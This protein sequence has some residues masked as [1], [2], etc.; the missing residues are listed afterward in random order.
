M[1]KIWL[2][3]QREYLTRVR[4]KSFIIMTILG[5]ILMAAFYAL[6]ILVA[7]SEE[8][9]EH[10]VMVVDTSPV[11]LGDALKYYNIRRPNSKLRFVWKY[12]TYDQARD[13][14]YNEN[15]SSILFIPRD[16][17]AHPAGMFLA[18]KER[19]SISIKNAIE[20]ELEKIIE[21]QKLLMY[22]IDPAVFDSV[23]VKVNLF[24]K[25][26][27]ETETGVREEV[28]FA[29]QKYVVSFISGML[30]YIFI[31]MYGVQVLRGVMEEKS[32]RIVEVIVSSVKP[33]QLMMGKI[34]GIAWV[35]LT[36]FLIWVVFSGI[37]ITVL[38]LAFAPNIMDQ[39]QSGSMQTQAEF[40]GMNVGSILEL[41]QVT[42]LSVM[43]GMFI[44]Y[45]LGG[46]L[47]Y[48]SL[49]AAIGSAIDSESDSQQFMLPITMPLIFSIAIGQSVLN[50]PEGALAQIFSFI[51][52]TSPIVMMVRI[53]FGVAYWELAVSAL[54]LIG[55]FVFTT[56][57]AARI[58]RTGI[59]MYGKKVTYKELWKWLWYKG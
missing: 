46:Y 39:V 3:I 6:L 26:I 35:G 18:F 2:V 51:P 23:R 28:E 33:F 11:K 29:E 45:F 16:P 14:I 49:F 17:V 21:E 8:E 24:E 13:S 12:D 37:V 38:S 34:I 52:L 10:R 20:I 5:P 58:Y 31:L 48:S 43:I 32:N 41:F 4:K 19:P 9:K 42:N 7:I 47:L 57:L 30:I 27:K 59:L 36:Q 1:N 25:K 56:W 44:F 40:G 15:Y 22:N 53:P 50:N 55:G 54:L